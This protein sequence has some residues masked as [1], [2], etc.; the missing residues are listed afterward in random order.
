[1]CPFPWNKPKSSE[2]LVRKSISNLA[3][4]C[5]CYDITEETT[6]EVLNQVGYDILGH[7]W[8]FPFQW[9]EKFQLGFFSPNNSKNRYLGIWY[10]NITP[11]TIVWVA[12][13][14][15]PL[16][17]SSGVMKIGENGNLI[18]LDHTGN[19]TWS[20]DIQT[21]SS[22]TSVAQLLD[23]GNLVLRDDS[24]PNTERYLWQ[25]FDNPSDTMLAGM[26]LGWDLRIGL[27]RY[28][29][30]WNSADDPSPGEFSY[31]IDLHGLP[32]LVLRKGSVNLFRSGPWGG[33]QFSGVHITPNLAF[34]PKVIADPEEVYY[35][36]DLYN[37]STLTM[38]VL[39]YSGALQRLVWN[40]SSLEWLVMHALPNDKCDNYDQCGSNAICTISDARICSCFTGY[41]PKSSQDWDML[42]W[43][44][45]CIRR[46]PLNCPT[47]EGFIELVGVKMPDLLQFWMNTSMTLEDCREECLKNCSCTAYA[48]S[49]ANG[50]GN[51]CLL[52]FGDLIDVRKLTEYGNQK[53]YI[54]VTASD[55][56]SKSDSR[57][58]VMVVVTISASIALVV[59]F[60]AS[61][62]IW[63]RNLQQGTHPEIQAGDEENLELPIF[64]MV[65]IAEA[66]HNFSYSNKIGEG[67]FGPV[68]KGQLSTGQ[69]IAVK[70]LSESSQQG[71]NEL[72]N[73]V[74]LIAKLQHRNLVRLLGYC[75]QGVERM[76]IYEYMP[77]GSLDSFIFDNA[78]STFLVWKRRFDIIVGIARGLLYL[79]RDSRLK[80]IHRDLKASNVLLDSEMNPKISDFGLARCFG[81]DQSS[82]KTRRVVG[83]YGYMSPEYAIDGLFSTKSDAYSF[84]V[85]VLEM[86]NGKRNRQFHHPDHDFNL[87]GHAWKLWTEGKAFDLIDPLMEDSFP[88][89]EVLRCIQVGLLCVQQCPED[90]PTMSLVLLMLDNE[91]A[92]LPQPKR[93]GFYTERSPEEVESSAGRIWTTNEVTNTLLEGR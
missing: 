59:L 15:H 23:S 51:G 63:R 57:K 62:I 34:I 64:N 29:K 82:A 28:L 7:H 17:D 21:M 93:P 49:N 55:L 77:N 18:L 76:L 86:V 52:W 47:G 60:I 83:T 53:L 46:N 66:T 69:E 38:C 9:R 73:E 33:V 91:S 50:G 4:P 68:Y 43:S 11:Q 85:L 80:I 37:E 89:S 3:K 90:R 36:Y 1:M 87:L 79:H 88:M 48:N 39:S 19:V 67:G 84:G 27:N 71:L 58:K 45:G 26:K 13:R 92:M 72:K 56:V 61:Y 42:I 22:K 10:Y 30:S 14:N 35:E 5:H 2:V 40:N 78:R 32:Q 31:G 74:M 20:T 41:I 70:R 25:S 8:S 6:A 54:R 44:G 65:T 12:N 75:I 16:N 24:K 81:G